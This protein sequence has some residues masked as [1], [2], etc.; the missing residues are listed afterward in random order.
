[1]N[2]N[3]TLDVKLYA[4]PEIEAALKILRGTGIDTHPY[5]K[6]ALRRG[7]TYLVRQG[8]S[9][10]K[11]GMDKT[12]EHTGNLERAFS[13][14]VKRSQPGALAGFILT[15]TTA[16]GR[17][18]KGYHAALVDR[19]TTSRYTSSGAYRGRGGH[20]KN[21]HSSSLSFWTSTRDN[22]ADEALRRVEEGLDTAIAKIMGAQGS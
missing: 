9:K 13:A 10:L 16:D 18:L 1:M 21:S 3:V 17:E 2:S 12:V 5:I 11:R 4:S 22:D 14:R 8:R 20:G 15:G 7:V 6:R 19:G